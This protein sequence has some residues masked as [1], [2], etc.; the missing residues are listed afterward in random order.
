MEDDEKTSKKIAQR[1]VII[2]T[3]FY[4]DGL[5]LV[6]ESMITT[7]CGIHILQ[8]LYNVRLATSMIWKEYAFSYLGSDTILSTRGNPIYER[9][10]LSRMQARTPQAMSAIIAAVEL[11]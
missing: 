3:D 2:R 9:I 4:V 5:K 8:L 1:N 10:K 11:D 6:Q 7:E